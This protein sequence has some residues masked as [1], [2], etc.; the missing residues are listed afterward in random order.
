MEIKQVVSNVLE[1][2]VFV[3]SKKS[4]AIIID[5]GADLTAVKAAVAGQNVDGVFLTH[6]HYDHA[7]YAPLYAKTFGC[8]I[9]ALKEIKDILADGQANCSDGKLVVDDFS[10]FVFVEDGTQLHL[11]EFAVDV[12]GT[13]GHSKDSACYLIDGQL[14]AGDTIFAQ[15]IGR[16]DLTSG[17]ADKLLKS[18][19]KIEKINYENVYSGHGSSSSRKHQSLNIRFFKVYLKKQQEKFIGE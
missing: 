10:D 2:N 19:E 9:F 11:G 5:A 13:P 8:K 14:F 4:R 16:T 3:L 6:G 15:G 12:F 7:L 1:S 18:L 17:D